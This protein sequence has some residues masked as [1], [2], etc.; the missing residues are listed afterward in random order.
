MGAV[1][2]G[3]LYPLLL[4]ALTG[5]TI[6]VGAPFFDLT[7]GALMTPLLLVMPFGPLLAWKRA[8]LVAAGQR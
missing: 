2:V 8:D 1:L 6:S 5:T 7:F 4:D 3:T